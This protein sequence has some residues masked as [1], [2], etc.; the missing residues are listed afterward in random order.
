MLG[1]RARKDFKTRVSPRDKSNQSGGPFIAPEPWRELSGMRDHN[2]NRS[3]SVHDGLSSWSPPSEPQSHI[4]HQDALD[5]TL[6]RRASDP[7]ELVLE[8]DSGE[9][10]LRDSKNN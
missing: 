6:F 3:V 7:Y 8:L 2:Q 10:R 5:A 1:P 9:L 4:E